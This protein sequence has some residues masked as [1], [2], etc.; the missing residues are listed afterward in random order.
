MNTLYRRRLFLTLGLAFLL[1]VPGAL[2]GAVTGRIVHQS[3]AQAYVCDGVTGYPQWDDYSGAA[4]DPNG[5]TMDWVV[6]QYG[7]LVKGPGIPAGKWGTG[8][9]AVFF[10]PA[11]PDPAKACLQNCQGVNQGCELACKKDRDDCMKADPK[12]PQACA[13]AFRTCMSGCARELKK[14]NAKCTSNPP[15]PLPPPPSP[16][17]ET[18]LQSCKK[19]SQADDLACKKDRDD[20]M[21]ADPKTP[22]ACATAFNTCKSG[23]ARQLKKCNAKCK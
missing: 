16:T 12:T 1:G 8:I 2:V 5:T 3:G 11:P 23:S 13:T 22:Q 21:K 17:R 6:Q 4:R 19:A 15:Q 14:C 9:A 10:A 7:G 18:C 20:C